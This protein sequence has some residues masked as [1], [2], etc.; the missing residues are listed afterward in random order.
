VTVH[1]LIIP[2]TRQQNLFTCNNL[3]NLLIQC[4]VFVSVF[5]SNFQYSEPRSVIVIPIFLTFV[6]SNAEAS[7]LNALTQGFSG[8]SLLD[9]CLMGV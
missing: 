6:S 4:G 7:Q 5:P 1:A 9:A 2:K 3:T 8:H